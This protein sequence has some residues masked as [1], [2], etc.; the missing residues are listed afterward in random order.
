MG[1]MAEKCPATAQQNVNIV[2][3]EEVCVIKEMA[4]A[5]LGEPVYNEEVS[6]LEQGEDV[7]M[8]QGEMLLA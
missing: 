2:E 4:I 8:D 3:V 5:D 1:H 6:Q 7:P